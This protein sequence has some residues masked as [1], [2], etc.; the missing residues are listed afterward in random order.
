MLGARF[1]VAARRF[2]SFPLV[3]AIWGHWARHMMQPS[4]AYLFLDVDGY[5]TGGIDQRRIVSQ[6]ADGYRARELGWAS[7]TADAHAAGSIYFYDASAPPLTTDAGVR[8]V[9]RLHG[10]PIWPEAGAY[11][12]ETVL[13]STRLLEAFRAIHDAVAAATR[14][15][16]VIV[17][18]GGNEGFWAQQ[19]LGPDIITLDL[20]RHGCPKVDVLGRDLARP[21]Q[22][23]GQPCR[24]HAITKRRAQ[25]VV[26]CPR[27][28]LHLLA[29]WVAA[30]KLKN[31]E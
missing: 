4:Y 26:H 22:A 2:R 8:H 7:Y 25:K 21:E 5:C 24:Y 3:R 9:H 23:P 27:L 31:L 10:L 6:A 17:H 28:E 16:V 20:G 11:P 1:L 15:P 29:E 14:L 30:R 12:G 19:A 13:C 18:K